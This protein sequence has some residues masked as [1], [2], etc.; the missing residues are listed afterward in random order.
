MMT[1]IALDEGAASSRADLDMMETALMTLAGNLPA[2]EMAIVRYN[3]ET[4]PPITAQ[5]GVDIVGT[6]GEQLSLVRTASA[7]EKSDQFD[8]LTSTFS[9]LTRIDADPGSR[10]FMITPGRL[11]GE[12]ESTGARLDSV[13]ELYRTEGWTIDV[14]TL[15]TSESAVRDLMSRLPES[16]G[17]NYY[18]LGQPSGLQSLLFEASGVNLETVIE[19]ELAGAELTSTFDVAPMTENARV[20]CLRYE[21]HTSSLG[22]E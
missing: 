17:G 22:R 4:T 9:F 5:S 3:T 15:L 19:A 6:A 12:S 16:S 8:V 18:D 14:A 2:G 7:P 13:G 1:V 11:L 21:V 20:A 10:V